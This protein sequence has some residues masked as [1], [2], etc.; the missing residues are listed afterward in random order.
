MATDKILESNIKVF[1]RLVF[2]DSFIDFAKMTS[3]I[4]KNFLEVKISVNGKMKKV[5]Y[6][7]EH[8]VRGC[9]PSNADVIIDF[10]RTSYPSY[11]S[12]RFR[13]CKNRDSSLRWLVP[14][15]SKLTNIFHV[16]GPSFL[17]SIALRLVTTVPFLN[18]LLFRDCYIHLLR[19]RSD[20]S[21][22]GNFDVMYAGI[23]GA[24]QKVVSF[25]SKSKLEYT[26]LPIGPLAVGSLMLESTILE[27][28]QDSV[29]SKYVPK[30]EV[31]G[32]G[33]SISRVPG[34]KN[35]KAKF[36][37]LHYQFIAD[38][39]K[40]DFRENDSSLFKEAKNFFSDREIKDD[41]PQRKTLNLMA[42]KCRNFNMSKI[43]TS[44]A[45]GDF[46]PWN[47][48]I[49]DD[50]IS[51]FDWEMS[52]VAAPLYF[53]VFHY[54]FYSSVFVEKASFSDIFV[55]LQFVFLKFF[56]E[57]SDEIFIKYM[58]LYIY[59]QSYRF[60]RALDSSSE[61]PVMQAAWMLEVWISSLDYFDQ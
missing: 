58:F 21:H 6:V 44:L 14:E 43:S 39:R 45:H 48:A 27:Q 15:A 31:T 28:L 25:D 55:K 24:H 20:D 41:A 9:S 1:I 42:L 2:F 30:C 26:K 51:V 35:Q 7:R 23:V 38:L 8:A 54:I 19:D 10:N 56:P 13:Y 12:F 36:S 18:A 61:E 22:I 47:V 60:L 50:Y 46:T 3:H 49:S 37:A 40:I 33:L 5:Y 32:D 11:D 59:I 17:K 57:V 34:S 29:V 52:L 4:D 53:D 16:Y